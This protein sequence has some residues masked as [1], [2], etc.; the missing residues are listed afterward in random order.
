MRA[1]A[2]D[3]STATRKVTDAALHGREVRSDATPWPPTGRASAVGPADDKKD[4]KKDEGKKDERKDDHHDQNAG[5]ANDEK[6]DGNAPKNVY[7]SKR[8][9]PGW[10]AAFQRGKGVLTKNNVKN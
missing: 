2:H 3:L 5:D 10:P 8:A 9:A 4:E 7:E 1:R 6:I